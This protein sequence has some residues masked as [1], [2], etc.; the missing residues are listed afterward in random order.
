MDSRATVRAELQPCA[1]IPGRRSRL[2]AI[3]AYE[4]ELQVFITFARSS[5]HSPHRQIN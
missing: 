5:Y 4:L 1:K 2:A 3:G